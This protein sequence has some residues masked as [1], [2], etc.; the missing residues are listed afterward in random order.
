MSGKPSLNF[1][2]WY[3]LIDTSQILAL[4]SN[5]RARMLSHCHITCSVT[6][7][8]EV[9]L[10]QAGSLRSHPRFSLT[11]DVWPYINAT[12]GRIKK[13]AT[14]LLL[15]WNPRNVLSDLSKVTLNC[16]CLWSLSYWKKKGE[17]EWYLMSQNDTG[18]MKYIFKDSAKC[19]KTQGIIH[20]LCQWS[21][22]LCSMCYYRFLITDFHSVSRF[23][24]CLLKALNSKQRRGVSPPG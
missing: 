21:P 11:L 17:K 20:L 7:G 10:V 2:A 19:S 1:P 16:P 24:F 22:S 18:Q 15:Q 23:L 5:P 8:Q 9:G 6:M 14:L 3:I 13:V 12:Y 4:L